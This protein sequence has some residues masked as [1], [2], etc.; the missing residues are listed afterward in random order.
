[1]DEFIKKN[2]GPLIAMS[3]AA[4]GLLVLIVISALANLPQAS[5]TE[6]GPVN[7]WESIFWLILIGLLIVG[8]VLFVRERLADSDPA[9][10]AEQEK[11]EILTLADTDNGFAQQIKKLFGTT[12]M[13]QITT[14]IQAMYAELEELR[15]KG[16][17]DQKEAEDLAPKVK[18]KERMIAALTSE[19]D[20]AQAAREKWQTK[21]ISSTK[22]V[23][24][25]R[26][27]L[28][29]KW[30][31]VPEK[32]LTAFLTT[33]TIKDGHSE[34]A[35]ISSKRRQ[36]RLMQRLSVEGYSIVQKAS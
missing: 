33:V 2:K 36:R 13:N 8:I 16:G 1:M 11:E 9:E 30:Q 5:Q 12:D 24:K 28:K 18:E 17:T 23:A 34:N 25:L 21:A 31:L 35:F 10:K 22:E 15:A 7:I 14:G 32:D 19:R 29:D 4:I 3:S 6:S 20:Q 26:E 27:E